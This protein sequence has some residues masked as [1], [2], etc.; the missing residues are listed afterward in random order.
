M[1]REKPRAPASCAIC[2]ADI[3]PNA[4]ACPECGADDRTGW[5]EQSS[6][7][8]LDLPEEAFDPAD[9]VDK[10][11]GRERPRRGKTLFWWI[12]ALLLLAV[13]VLGL[14]NRLGI[15]P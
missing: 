14:I 15:A 4:R 7:D 13:V 2:G 1:S 9:H 12:V 10:E 6:Y 5:R 3:P 8:G 11:Y